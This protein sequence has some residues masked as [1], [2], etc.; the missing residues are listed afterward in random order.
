MFPDPVYILEHSRI[1]KFLEKLKSGSMFKYRKRTTIL[2]NISI[3]IKF[4]T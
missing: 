2:K 1:G 4:M 3:M